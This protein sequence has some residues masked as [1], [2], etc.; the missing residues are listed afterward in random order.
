M[1]HK[2][3]QNALPLKKKIPAIQTVCP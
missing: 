2:A 3:D 1:L